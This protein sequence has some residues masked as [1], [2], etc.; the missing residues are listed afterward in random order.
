MIDEYDL[1]PWKPHLNK[2]IGNEFLAKKFNFYFWMKMKYCG[3]TLILPAI[4]FL[5]KTVIFLKEIF[6]KNLSKSI[7][8]GSIIIIKI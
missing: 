6:S 2:I 5:V 3:Y 8:E 1:K 7:H 4:S